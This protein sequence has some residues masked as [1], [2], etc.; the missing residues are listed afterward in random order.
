MT[1]RIPE[2]VGRVFS[3]GAATSGWGRRAFGG[4]PL[5]WI[6]HEGLE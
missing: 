2:I 3:I 1:A 4:R 6:I 5:A